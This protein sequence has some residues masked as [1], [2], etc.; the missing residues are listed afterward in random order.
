MAP[1]YNESEPEVQEDAPV[2][3]GID[4]QAEDERAATGTEQQQAANEAENLDQDV[5]TPFLFVLPSASP[6]DEE[7]RDADPARLP[8]SL[9]SSFVLVEHHRQLCRRVDPR[10]QGGRHEAGQGDRQRRRRRD[11]GRRAVV[12][13]GAATDTTLL[14]MLL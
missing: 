8:T 2:D 3:S 5:S 4:A 10:S 14:C 1:Q 6:L 11:Q 13:Q 7:D 9:D 12:S